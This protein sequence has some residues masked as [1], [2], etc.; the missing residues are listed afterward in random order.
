M[1]TNLATNNL[2][3]IAPNRKSSTVATTDRNVIALII[4]VN[5]NRESLMSQNISPLLCVE[6]IVVGKFFKMVTSVVA[7]IREKAI[8]V[9]IRLV[10]ISR[11]E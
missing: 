1:Q 9:I 3:K 8:T 5:V 4:T 6:I 2:G 10:R 7:S 11:E